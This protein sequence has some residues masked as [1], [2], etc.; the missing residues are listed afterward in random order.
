MQG[1]RILMVAYLLSA[2]S[3][4]AQAPAAPAAPAPSAPPTPTAPPAPGSPRAP[5]PPPSVVAGIPVNYYEAKVGEYTLIDPLTLNN[6]KRVTNA[7]TWWTKRRPE[8]E[9]I[10]ETEQYGRDPG[11]PAEESFDVT[12]KGTP[13]LNGKAIRKQVTISFSRDPTWPKIH[14]LIYLPAAAHKPVPMFF[15]I[16]FGAIQSA[17]DDPGITPI[18]VWDPRTNKKMLPPPGRGFGRIDIEPILDAGFGVATYYYGDVDP[19]F[20]TGFPNGIRAKYLK[21]GQTERAPDD[22]GS[23]AAWA[24]GMSRV[25]DYFET[26]TAI[27]AKR[28]AIHGVSRLG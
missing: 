18:E 14:L 1:K 2:L 28:V 16:N 6:G 7:K 5:Q 17:V 13:A 11:R 24:W 12:D 19:D 23:I 27:D 9:A 26:D 21:P 8:I 4:H 10:F 25:Q 15:T 20:L 3:L 22:W